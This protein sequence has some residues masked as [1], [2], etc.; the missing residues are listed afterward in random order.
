MIYSNRGIPRHLDR[1]DLI[2]RLCAGKSVL[3][4]GATDAPFTAEKYERGLLLHTKLSNC[5]ASVVGI[6]IDAEA[7]SYL[8]ERGIENIEHFDMNSAGALNFVPDVVVFGEIIEHLVNFEAAFCNLRAAMDSH[9]V[10]IIT[11][12]N[13]FYVL[14]F[15]RLLLFN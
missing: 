8:S 10:L 5:A 3:H 1:D 15:L 4:I 9:T 7:I 2:C 13:L 12:P 11:T 14:P 6:D